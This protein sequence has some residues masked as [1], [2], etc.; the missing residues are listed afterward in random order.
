MNTTR[1]NFNMPKEIIIT[2]SWL[3]WLIEGDGS[4]HLW[5]KDLIPVFAIVLTIKEL[6]VLEKIR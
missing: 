3:I 1:I 6:L 5:R 2:K 4:F